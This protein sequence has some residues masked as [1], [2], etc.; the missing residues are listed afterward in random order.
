MIPAGY[1]IALAL[2]T[3]IAFVVVGMMETHRER[4]IYH[5]AYQRK[6]KQQKDLS[7]AKRA[8]KIRYRSV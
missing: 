1:L 5:S 4:R 7:D 8:E 3:A 2:A 6:L